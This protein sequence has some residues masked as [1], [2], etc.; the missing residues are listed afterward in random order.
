MT[1]DAGG[2]GGARLIE[3]REI[4][5][6]N[7]SL[8]VGELPSTLPFVA[9]RFF[10]LYGIPAG[11]ARGTHAHRACEQFLVCLRGSVTALIDDG[12]TSREIVLDRPDLGLYMPP[13]TWGTQRDYSPDAL[14]LVFA[15]H[16]YEAADYIEDYE[17][18]R[19]L[20]AG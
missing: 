16:E 3:L 18:F 6:D 9:R 12:S 11:E 2:A 20:T 19:A 14:L 1:D 4:V 8:V 5:A 10:A 7:G 13:L 15:S 17:E